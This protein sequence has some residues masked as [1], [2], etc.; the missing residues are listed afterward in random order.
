[1]KKLLKNG[2]L[3]RTEIKEDPYGLGVWL[4]RGQGTGLAFGY[5]FVNPGYRRNY[6]KVVV[7][8]KA[9]EKRLRDLHDNV[10]YPVQKHLRRMLEELG[11]VG[12]RRCRTP[13]H[14]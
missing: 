2:I 5:R 4:P 9:L 6:A 13:R 11:T 7:T 14:C 10:R 3:E 1:M 8:N 12:A